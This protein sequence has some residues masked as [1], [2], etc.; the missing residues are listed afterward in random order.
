MEKLMAKRWIGVIILVVIALVSMF[1]LSKVATSPQFHADTIETL[2]DKKLTV[3]ELAGAT[4]LASTAIAAI[5]YDATTPLAG[6]I[7]ELSEYLLIIVGII[8]FEK[9][10][11]TLTGY[12]TFSFLIPL[13]CVLFAIYL[14]SRNENLKRFGTKLVAFGLIIFMVVPVSVKITD[15]IE[16]TFDST[17]MQAIESSKDIDFSENDEKDEQ[18]EDEG[19]WSGLVTGAQNAISSIG[20]GI[21][22]ILDKC[23]NVLN[24]FIDA[25]AVLLI[26][27]CV[28]PILVLLF[29]VWL[30]KM[31]FGI[32]VPVNKVF[33]LPKKNK[34]DKIEK[35][36]LKQLGE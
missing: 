25:V 17:I 24:N 3:M 15:I 18:S 33:A 6:Q 19:F 14:Y 7:I 34:K 13:A 4:A 23:K 28:I 31:A 8:F 26:T 21:S 36:E 32:T 11:L 9:M 10:M 29:M 30:I 2:D 20:D 1:G 27:S 16:A 22:N 5:P 12:A 35:E